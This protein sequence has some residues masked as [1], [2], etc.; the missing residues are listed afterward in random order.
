VLDAMEKLGADRARIAAAVGPCIAQE[1]Y[2]VGAEFQNRFAAPDSANARYFVPS[3]KQDH[4][5]FDLETYVIHRLAAA[6]VENVDASH[7]DTYARSA[8]FFSFR[9]NT[10]RAEANYGRQISAIALTP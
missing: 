1:S 6:G 10:H 3:D 9:R 2:E 5:R 4:F 8:D 7:A